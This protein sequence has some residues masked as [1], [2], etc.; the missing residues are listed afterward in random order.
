MNTLTTLIRTAPGIGIALA[1][2][3]ACGGGGGGGGLGGP[4]L[5]NPTDDW[6]IDPQV[7][8][9]GGPGKDGI[10]AL[11][12][13]AF[14]PIADNQPDFSNDLVIGMKIG[15]QVKV[16]PHD[17]M[18][19]HEIVND[20]VPA[21]PVILS[22][23][24][25]TGSALAWKGNPAHADPTFGVSGQLYNSNLLPYDR[26]TDSLWS[27]MLEIA[28]HGDRVREQPERLQV[29]ETTWATI[30]AMY[31]DAVQMTR[32]TGHVRN[33]DNYPYGT[34]RSS[35][36]LLFPVQN[37]DNR[38]HRKTRVIGIRTSAGAARSTRSTVSVRRHRRSMIS[39]TISRSL[40]SV[41]RT[42]IS[43]RFTVAS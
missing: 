25:L 18:D 14:G 19:Y 43:Q 32:D 12:N 9:D 1:T 8:V 39:S 27:Q 6:V 31:P 33:Y 11:E 26:E 7:V 4:V 22:Y 5:V 10:P 24:P 3:A 2:L 40:L 34:F 30:R 21:N 15:G 36:N 41:T 16:Y 38:L 29:V 42:R 23:C 35:T 13:P 37:D 20:E 17:I 28:V